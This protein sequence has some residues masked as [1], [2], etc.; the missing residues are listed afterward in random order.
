[1]HGDGQGLLI[2]WWGESGLRRFTEHTYTGGDMDTGTINM[3][4]CLVYCNC[5]CQLDYEYT[6]T[7]R[8]GGHAM[9]AVLFC[10]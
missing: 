5:N 9:I 3:Y 8:R 6:T 2:G 10:K 4:Q 7:R 1:M